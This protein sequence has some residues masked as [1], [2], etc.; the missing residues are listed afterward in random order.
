MIKEYFN[1]LKNYISLGVINKALVF[2]V[3]FSYIL[4]SLSSLLIPYFAASIADYAMVSDFKM[5]F[6]VAIVLLIV[7]CIYL[8]CSHYR[9]YA[10]HKNNIYIHNR[11]EQLIL[12]KV[13]SYDDYYTDYISKSRIINTSYEDLNCVM[14][15]MDETLN[16]GSACLTIIGSIIIL[17]TTNIYIGFLTLV[18]NIIAMYRLIKNMMKRDHYLLNRKKHQDNVSNLLNQVLDGNKEINAFNMESTLENY[19]NDY[20]R[21]W[22][23]DYKLETIYDN[24]VYVTVPT[25]LG[26]G[27]ICIYFILVYL[28]L[29]KRL[30]VS[31]LI[32]VIGYY[33]NI[34]TQFSYLYT[35]LN[36]LTRNLNSVDRIKNIVNYQSKYMIEFGDYNKENIDGILSLDKVRYSIDGNIILKDITHEFKPNTL[37]SI[38]G[39][40][41]SG[42]TILFKLILRL[43]KVDSGDIRL[44]NHN[45]YDYL[46][47]SYATNVALV[48]ENPFIFDM[49]IRE[50]LSLIDSST[51]H[52]IEVC[53]YL[54]IHDD[55]MSL[56]D[57]YK[58]K[59]VRDAE[60]ISIDMKIYLSIAR[61]ILSNAK[62]ILIDDL[63][64]HSTSI[65]MKKIVRIL[66]DL[67]KDKT[68]IVITDDEDIMH[69]SDEVLLLDK[70][71]LKDITKDK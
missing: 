43:I 21:Y 69:I 59:L 70:G 58:T 37:T 39:D 1:K 60:N 25:I 41:R 6:I 11:L 56:S 71:V 20:K 5:A 16:M 19:L 14:E 50:N 23:K 10:Y 67:K 7:A 13:T 51:K 28:I 17:I 62:V 54:G 15:I 65:D 27:K 26:V 33:E 31:T 18:L 36:L 45:I 47:S 57:G 68:I 61:A 42:K 22:K 38:M 34:Q 32:L 64:K 66:K 44:D 2:H 49:S 35:Q 3:I 53:K 63:F 4:Y 30:L 46:N 48:S 24:R 12:K 8:L 40:N 52:Q 29:D 9:Y 55:I